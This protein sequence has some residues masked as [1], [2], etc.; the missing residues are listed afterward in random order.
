[1]WTPDQVHESI[2]SDPL[3]GP[4]DAEVEEAVSAWF[5]ITRA[6][7]FEGST[8]LRRPVGAPLGGPELVEAGRRRLL[9]AR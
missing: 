9:A 6:G 4:E 2:R 3:D 1:V 5:A 7:N 8:I